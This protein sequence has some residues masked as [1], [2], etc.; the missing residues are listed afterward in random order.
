MLFYKYLELELALYLLFAILRPN[1]PVG[2][3][4]FQKHF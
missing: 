4:S 1:K 3:R 2:N